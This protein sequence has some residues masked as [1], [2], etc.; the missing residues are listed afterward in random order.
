MEE[1]YNIGISE[2][3]LKKI[4][5]Q[6]PEIIELDNE[7]IK[8]KIQILEKINCTKNQIINIIGSNPQ[9]LIRT[10]KKII[11]LLDYLI[12]IGFNMLDILL[13]ANPYILNLDSFEIKNYI[14]NRKIKGDTL[15]NIIEDLDENPILFN[16]M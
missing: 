12:E 8:E 3:T 1:L 10:N 2:E 7:D 11:E 6:E 4:I 5:Q 13:E 14:N 15:E 9:Y 16:E